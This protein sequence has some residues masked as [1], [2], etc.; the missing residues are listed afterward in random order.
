MGGRR[1]PVVDR[2]AR[3]ALAPRLG[4][5]GDGPRGAHGRRERHG[6]GSGASHI[7]VGQGS[8]P[9]KRMALALAVVLGLVVSEAGAGPTRSATPSGRTAAA[10]PAGAPQVTP[11][12][13]AAP[14]ATAPA[15][16]KPE[17]D[18]RTPERDKAERE[19]EDRNQPVTVDSDRMER[20]GKESLVIFSGNV[21]AR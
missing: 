6:V 15:A 9:M 21:V 4:R 5:E 17:P 19:K 18:A 10:R 2:C 13:V 16:A 14:A 12:R 3:P 8:T 7:R 20:F 11:V 1:A